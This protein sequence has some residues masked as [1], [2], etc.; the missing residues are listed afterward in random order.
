MTAPSA[1]ATEQHA[2]ELP[3]HDVL[4]R[5]KLDALTLEWVRERADLDRGVFA[6]RWPSESTWEIWTTAGQA[7]GW[8]VRLSVHPSLDAARSSR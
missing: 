7:T 6:V 3:T 4:T 1:F 2:P 5:R 8:A